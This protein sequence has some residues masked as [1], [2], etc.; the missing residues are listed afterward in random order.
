MK[1]RHKVPKKLYERASRAAQN[2][3]RYEPIERYV[4]ERVVQASKQDVTVDD[5]FIKLA[6]KIL[7]EQPAYIPHDEKKRMV[8]QAI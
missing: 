4:I 6:N 8:R 2:I 3:F 1:N 7:V 5:V